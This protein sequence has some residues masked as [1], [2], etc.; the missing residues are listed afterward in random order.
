MDPDERWMA[1]VRG[2]HRDYSRMLRHGIGQVLILPSLGGDKV[3]TVRDAARRADAI[4]DKLLRN[5]DQQRWWS[6]SPDF[7]LLAEAS[8]GAFL[9]AIDAAVSF[10]AVTPSS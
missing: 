7:R 1:P 9:S 6:L 2:I 8:P 3:R 4:V 5:A 10:G